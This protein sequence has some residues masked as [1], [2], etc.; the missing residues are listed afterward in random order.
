MSSM[1]LASVTEQLKMTLAPLQTVPSLT[2]NWTPS[3]G[4]A[5]DEHSLSTDVIT[6]NQPWTISTSDLMI[7]SPSFKN[8]E[9]SF[10]SLGTRAEEN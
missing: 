3:G 4:S 6:T 8:P 7:T 9:S 1:G 5:K 2:S 10:E